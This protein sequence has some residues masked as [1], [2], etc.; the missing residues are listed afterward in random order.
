VKEL[1]N[2]YNTKVVLECWSV[3]S[4]ADQCFANERVGPH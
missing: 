4:F 1:P 2:A 3:N